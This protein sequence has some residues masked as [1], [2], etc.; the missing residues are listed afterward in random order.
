[1]TPTKASSARFASA[2]PLKT[3]MIP[4]L[5]RSPASRL[6]APRTPQTEFNPRIKKTLPSLGNLKSILRRH[7]PIF[8]NDPVKIAAGTHIAT[9]GFNP[10]IKFTD[11]PTTTF[12]DESGRTP[13]PKKRVEFTP[14]TESRYELAQSSP[15]PSKLPAP[16]VVPAS[17]D[18]VYPKLPS[19]PSDKEKDDTPTIRRVRDSAVAARTSPFPNLPAV[20]HGITTKKRQ[21]EEDEH[22]NKSSE[23]ATKSA[24][25]ASTRTSPFPNMP[26]VPHGIM[27]KKRHREEVD[28]DQDSEN[29]PPADAPSDEQRS[30]KRLKPS[31]IRAAPAASPSPL[32]SR[33]TATGRLTGSRAGTPSTTTKKGILSLS[34]LNML[35]KPKSHR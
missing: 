7:Q 22:E 5:K 34:R 4:S 12:G 31:T 33:A 26:A 35:A 9:P 18:V 14:S 17:S 2:K 25:T 10:D 3:S 23:K 32:K 24:S 6:A 13:S 15:S 11:F 8:S 20:P 29:I 1:M 19:F 27:N 21:R 30:A 28:N 16:H